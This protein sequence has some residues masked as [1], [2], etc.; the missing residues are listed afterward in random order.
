MIISSD[1]LTFKNRFWQPWICNKQIFL[2]IQKNIES[3][4]NFLKWD[5]EIRA[6]PKLFVFWQYLVIHWSSRI[7]FD[8]HKLY[9]SR[10]ITYSK[11][12]QYYDLWYK[13]MYGAMVFNTG[14]GAM[15]FDTGY[16]AMVFDTT[17]IWSYLRIHWP[18][19]TDFD[20]HEFLINRSF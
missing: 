17:Y 19:R 2:A 7:D 12:R 6:T 5:L 13:C 9:T 3:S 1:L 20:N 18:S 16:G 14:Y 8:N 10:T 11:M 15:V 4:K